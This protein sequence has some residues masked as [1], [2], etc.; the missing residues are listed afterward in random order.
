MKVAEAGVIPAGSS[1]QTHFSLLTSEARVAL[2]QRLMLGHLALE[3]RPFA[4]STPLTL[5]SILALLEPDRVDSPVP[6]APRPPKRI[7]DSFFPWD[8]CPEPSHKDDLKRK[9]NRGK[10]PPHCSRESAIPLSFLVPV[11]HPHCLLCP[12]LLNSFWLLSGPKKKGLKPPLQAGV[13]S[14]LRIVHSIANGNFS[15]PL[16]DKHVPKCAIFFWPEDY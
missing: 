9:T 3:A 14:Y 2:D 6:A 7:F 16:Q 4:V 1:K 5:H 8:P 10:Q 13:R 11:N 15:V 12:I